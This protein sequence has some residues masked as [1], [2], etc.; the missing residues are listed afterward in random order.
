MDAFLL[1]GSNIDAEENI[2]KCLT[3]IKAI[4]K[5]ELI[6][7]SSIYRTEPFGYREQPYFLNLAVKVK[8][9]L[10]PRELLFEIKEIE[11]ALGRKRGVRWGPRAIDIDILFYGDKIIDEEGLKVPHPQV[12]LR[13]FALIPLKEIAPGLFH[14]VLKKRVD[15]LIKDAP[16]AEVVLW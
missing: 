10:S 16:E 9:G 5:T 14:P 12:H 8:T 6:S 1:L 4:S 2:E 7:T 3:L 13:K 11:K 15:E